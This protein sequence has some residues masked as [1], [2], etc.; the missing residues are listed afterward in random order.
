MPSKEVI[1]CQQILLQCFAAL[2]N[3]SRE[4]VKAE[5]VAYT[6]QQETQSDEEDWSDEEEMPGLI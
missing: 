1:T 4:E 2:G 5:V 3:T 6:G